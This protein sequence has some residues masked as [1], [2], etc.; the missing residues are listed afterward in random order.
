MKLP[1]SVVLDLL[2]LYLAGE[3]SMETRTLFELEFANDVELG[4]LVQ[5]LTKEETLDSN[6]MGVGIDAPR[7][8]VALQSFQRTRKLLRQQRRLFA[9]GLFFTLIS[10]SFEFTVANGRLQEAHL[11]MR[12]APWVYGSSLALGMLCWIWYFVL[13]QSLRINTTPKSVTHK[14]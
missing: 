6:K 14:D 7:P 8:E 10:V 4:A 9:F 12:D 2:P 1:R 5:R 3:L 13:Q 11:L